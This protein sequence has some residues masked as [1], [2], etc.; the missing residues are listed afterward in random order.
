MIDL[1]EQRRKYIAELCRRHEVRRLELFGSAARGDFEPVKSDL[2]FVVQ[3]TRTGYAGY[4]DAF[5]DFAE[6]LEKLFGRKVDLLTERMIR[7]PHFRA[8]VNASRQV[9]YEERG[10]TKT[11]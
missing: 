7:S 8:A 2:D 6:A 3:F 11:A 10:E 5:L 9:V 4:A 1:V